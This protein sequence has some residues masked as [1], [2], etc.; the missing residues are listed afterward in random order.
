MIANE[1]DFAIIE[2]D[3]SNTKK[4]DKHKVVLSK[5]GKTAFINDIVINK[6][7]EYIGKFNAVCF[8]PEDV[9]LFKDSPSIRRHFLDKELSSLFPVYVKQLIAFKNTLEQR[10]ALLKGKIDYALLEVIDDKLIE[11]SYDVYK[12]RKWI[13]GK[14]I[15]FAT[16]IYFG[17]R[18]F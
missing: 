3:I 15:E 4:V 12:R 1:S 17:W 18:T 5:S 7:S 14:I 13:I 9:S 6:V 10:N 16:K 2:G 11:T 8:S